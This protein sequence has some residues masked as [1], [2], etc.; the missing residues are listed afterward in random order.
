M[1]AG[2]WESLENTKFARVFCAFLPKVIKNLWSRS[3]GQQTESFDKS[4]N[5]ELLG[6]TRY[7]SYVFLNI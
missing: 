4:K 7:F 3:K 1:K 2:V 6:K 5:N